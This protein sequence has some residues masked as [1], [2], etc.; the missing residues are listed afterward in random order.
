MGDSLRSTSCANFILAVINAR[1]FVREGAS[2]T[3]KEI[4]RENLPLT[5]ASSASALSL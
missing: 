4:S 5:P 2:G 3:G 1:I